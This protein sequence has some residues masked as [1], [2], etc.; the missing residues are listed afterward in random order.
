MKMIS[1]ETGITIGQQLTIYL[2]FVGLV[3]FG[4]IFYDLI[5]NPEVGQYN[6]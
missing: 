2:L 1:A 5:K 3:I 4:F 6:E